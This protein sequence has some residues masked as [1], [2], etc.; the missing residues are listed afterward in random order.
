MA[1]LIAFAGL[2]QALARLCLRD[3]RQRK[4]IAEAAGINASMLSGFL[5]GRRTPSLEHL[6]RLLT[7]MNFTIE[8]LTYEMRAVGLRSSN[9]PLVVWPQFLHKQEGEAAAAILTTLLESVQTMLRE[10]ERDRARSENR[11]PYEGMTP[12]VDLPKLATR[13]KKRGKKTEG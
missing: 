3:G 2:P 7:E 13:P 10:Q 11:S 9:A 6:D 5:N 1:D 4:E 12:Y 8:D